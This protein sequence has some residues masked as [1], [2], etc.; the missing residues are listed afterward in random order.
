MYFLNYQRM[1]INFL[2]IT[3]IN[4]VMSLTELKPLF[5]NFEIHLL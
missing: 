2:H 3:E 4:Y 1:S 5:K